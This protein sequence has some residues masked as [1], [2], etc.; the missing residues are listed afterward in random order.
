MFCWSGFWIVEVFLQIFHTQMLKTCIKHTDLRGTVWTIFLFYSL[1]VFNSFFFSIEIN[2]RFLAHSSVTILTSS[3][4]SHSS[5]L[6]AECLPSERVGSTAQKTRTQN[7]TVEKI[8]RG[9]T[10]LAACRLKGHGFDC[11]KTTNKTH[12]SGS[13]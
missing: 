3:T 11:R 9:S 1:N 8:C 4:R 10:L 5:H 2:W 13:S 6:T 7:K 12:T